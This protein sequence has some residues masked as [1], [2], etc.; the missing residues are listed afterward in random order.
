MNFSSRG[1]VPSHFGNFGD[2]TSWTFPD[3]PFVF[4]EYV[5]NTLRQMYASRYDKTN[6]LRDV[7]H[8]EKLNAN[9]ARGAVYLDVTSLNIAYDR[10]ALGGV[11]DLGGLYLRNFWSD[12][13]T[14]SFV[15]KFSGSV[16]GNKET[17]RRSGIGAVFHARE[18]RLVSF[19]QRS[20]HFRGSGAGKQRR[21][22]RRRLHVT[23]HI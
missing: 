9:P 16:T 11:I 14:P 4:A 10:G 20:G 5:D 13:V 17:A 18:L 3:S 7:S 1:R 6:A 21:Q 12:V 22:Y 19:Y 23:Q 15:H 8:G 2:D